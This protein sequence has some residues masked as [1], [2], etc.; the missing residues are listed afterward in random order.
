M[1]LLTLYKLTLFIL[2]LSLVHPLSAASVNGSKLTSHFYRNKVSAVFAFGD[3]VLDPGNNNQLNTSAVRGNHLPYGRD[4]PHHPASGRFTNGKLFSDFLVSD[5]GLKDLLQ[6]FLDPK[7]TDRELLTGVSFA[8]GGSGYDLATKSNVMNMNKQLDYFREALGR[9]RKTVGFFRAD[10]LVNNALFLIVAGTND[11]TLSFY[12]LQTRRSQFNVS[13]YQKFLLHN[14]ESTVQRLY[15]LGA[16]K[17]AIGG[18]PPIGC[19]P[20]QVTIGSFIPSL[21]LFQRLCVEQQNL[22]AQAYNEK[23]QAV[24]YRLQ[25]LPG[26]RIAYIDLFTPLIDMVHRPLKYGFNKDSTKGCCGTGI[27]EIGDQCTSKVPTCRDASKYVF[28]DAIHPTQATY[29]V[30]ANTFE[31]NVLPRL[32]N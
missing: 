27:I 10:Y 16:R 13:S 32:F 14:M 30:L 25:G 28:F 17:I 1:Q 15:T 26:S 18:L 21:H 12:D 22:D 4:L 20:L 2:L 29:R 31:T 5:L 7:V 8:S 9:I 23:L 6:A 3:S 24:I 11:M 19:L